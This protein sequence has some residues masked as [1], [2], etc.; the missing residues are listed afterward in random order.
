MKI[1]IRCGA[2]RVSVLGLNFHRIVLL[3]TL[4]VNGITVLSDVQ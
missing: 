4:C 2:Q 3:G 1:N